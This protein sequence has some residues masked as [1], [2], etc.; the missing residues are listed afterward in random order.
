MPTQSQDEGGKPVGGIVRPRGDEKVR[1]TLMLCNSTVRRASAASLVTPS[2]RRWCLQ[3]ESVALRVADSLYVECP[4]AWPD[5]QNYSATKLLS[6]IH[7]DDGIRA[8]FG[9]SAW[10]MSSITVFCVEK[11]TAYQ[12]LQTG[13]AAAADALEEQAME[14]RECAPLTTFDVVGRVVQTIGVSDQHVVLIRV[15]PPAAAAG[16]CR[17]AMTCSICASG[18]CFVSLLPSMSVVCTVQVLQAGVLPVSGHHCA[19]SLSQPPSPHPNVMHSLHSL[20]RCARA[21]G[22]AS[23]GSGTGGSRLAYRSRQTVATLV[24]GDALPPTVPIP[25]CSSCCCCFATL[26]ARCVGPCA[27]RMRGHW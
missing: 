26:D 15:R 18:L 6:E 4:F 9:G 7:D 27:S 11:A 10:K 25:L 23:G 19:A 1:R 5:L 20:L 12:A 8:L 17:H 24:A 2:A 16:E 21:G 22:A 3:P 13:D 14:R